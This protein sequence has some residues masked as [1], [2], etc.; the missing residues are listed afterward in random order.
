MEHPASRPVTSSD[1]LA[2]GAS[3]QLLSLIFLQP[4]APRSV[5]TPDRQKQSMSPRVFISHSSED[6]TVAETICQRLEADGIKC[7]IAPGNIQPGSDWTK[8]IT[9][10]IDACQIVV[11]V[12]SKH[13]NE[14][15]HVYREVAKAFSAH[16]AVIPF[17]TELVSP[18]PSLGYYLN[19]VQWLDAIEPPLERH[20]AALV[21]RVKSWLAGSLVNERFRV[22]PAVVAEKPTTIRPSGILKSWTRKIPKRSQTWLLLCSA[23]SSFR[24]PGKCMTA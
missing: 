17:R 2:L 6:K 5:K 8:A 22:S 20:V 24:R 21:E 16:L 14:S 3:K 13:A 11:L 10:G 1:H 18:N 12:F 23:C 4:S 15:D 19:T 7:W 9:Q